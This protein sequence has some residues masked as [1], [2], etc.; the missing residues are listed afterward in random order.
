MNATRA[1]CFLQWLRGLM[2][3]YLPSVW[4]QLLTH[5]LATQPLPCRTIDKKGRV[6]GRFPQTTCMSWLRIIE[7]VYCYYSIMS[8]DAR[9]YSVVYVY[10]V[11]TPICKGSKSWQ[12][13]VMVLCCSLRHD[14][15]GYALHFFI[16][17]LTTTGGGR[18]FG[19]SFCRF[20]DH[21]IVTI[22][23]FLSVS[24]VLFF[25]ACKL[26]L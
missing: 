20:L 2:S 24:G 13:I 12:S 11:S 3:A 23:H 10:G 9:W 19:Q 6:A 18:V 7:V 22:C 14:R 5:F 17:R 4:E 15:S 25:L 26:P 8:V 1:L 21:R 16:S